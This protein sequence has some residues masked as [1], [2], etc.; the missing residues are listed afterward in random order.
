MS[1]LVSINQAP[2]LLASVMPENPQH[3]DMVLMPEGYSC[4]E[5]DDIQVYKGAT[6]IGI[7][8]A[9]QRIDNV[10]NMYMATRLATSVPITPGDILQVMNVHHTLVSME[11]VEYLGWVGCRKG[12]IRDVTHNAHYE[13]LDTVIIAE[14]D[15]MVVHE[16]VCLKQYKEGEH[17][18]KPT[19]PGTGTD[20]R[21]PETTDTEGGSESSE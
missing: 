6:R 10:S 19:S 21:R 8:S 2:E 12:A 15:D 20:D 17:N 18:A 4:G 9:L 7:A 14:N 16:Q 5:T 13:I 3:G 11:F 1:Q